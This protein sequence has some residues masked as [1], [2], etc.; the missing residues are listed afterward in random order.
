MDVGCGQLLIDGKVKL[1]QGVEIERLTPKGVVYTDGTT[2][3]VDAIIFALVLVQIR[4][5]LCAYIF[6][7]N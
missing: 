6:L 4:R 2:Q 3:D 7:C 5:I 1:K